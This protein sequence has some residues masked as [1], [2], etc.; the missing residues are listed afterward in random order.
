MIKVC[1]L[2][3]T[4]QVADLLDSIR[5]PVSNKAS[6]LSTSSMQPI[7]DYRLA[8]VFCFV[9]SQVHGQFSS[10]T[11]V[12]DIFPQLKD[13][14]LNPAPIKSL[15]LGG[16]NFDHCCLVAV[17]QSLAINQDGNLTKIGNPSFIVDDIETF[18]RSQF[19]C[20]A[21]YN[22]DRNGT[23]IVK[24]PYKWCRDTCPG[25]QRS[26][27]SD[28]NQ[29]VN[30]FA[31]FIIPAVVFCL[32]V[33]RQ[34]K[35]AIP[36]ALFDIPFNRLVPILS[37][38]FIALIAGVIVTVDTMIWLIVIFALAGPILLSGIFE[39]FI[40]NRI[41]AYLR[42]SIENHRLTTEQRARLIYTVLIGNLNMLKEPPKEIGSGN[43]AWKHVADLLQRLQF[44]GSQN[45]KTRLRTILSAQYSFGVTVGAP[46]IFFGASFVYTLVGNYAN[47]GN[48]DT[49]N[50]LGEDSGCHLHSVLQALTSGS[51]WRI[52]ANHSTYCNSQWASFGWK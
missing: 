47:Y 38:P 22:N 32:S 26:Q 6:R 45:T 18:Q 16:Q 25:W 21:S 41:L 2:A 31:G 37:V 9:L 3:A 5:Y 7:W 10:G 15:H 28:L 12:A 13:L 8:A 14:Q 29:W 24:V 49:S 1:A 51:L 40:D 33:P 42:D 52:L 23:P 19:P 46:V 20:A 17:N 30:P 34:R 11:E 36:E 44:E 27:T 35:I 50:A 43:T 4:S 48:V 39:A